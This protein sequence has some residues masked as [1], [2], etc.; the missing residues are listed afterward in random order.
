MQPL[1]ITLP[2]VSGQVL[3]YGGC[4]TVHATRETSGSAVATYRFWDGVN[5]KGQL[6]LPVQLGASEST[7]D[8]FREHHITFKN[9]LYYELVDGAIEGTVSVLV[10]HECDK[11][12]KALFYQAMTAA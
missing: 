11:V 7:R 12:L 3:N 10:E 8:D 4:L 2:A 9:G 1:T 6:I 5:N